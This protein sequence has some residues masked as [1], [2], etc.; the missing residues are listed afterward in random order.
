MAILKKSDR[1]RIE[2]AVIDEG[3]LE[4]MN[5]ILKDHGVIDVELAGLRFKTAGIPP[6]PNEDCN[7]NT[8]QWKYK[9][10]GSDCKWR[11]VRKRP[12]E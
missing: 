7:P 2:A 8:H 9:C 11:C 10:V 12:S 1:A 5:Q 4:K 3:M 6:I